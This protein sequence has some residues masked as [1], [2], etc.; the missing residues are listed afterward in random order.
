MESNFWMGMAYGC[1]EVW[2]KI[3]Q[4]DKRV[5][6]DLSGNLA[7]P[8]RPSINGFYFAFIKLALFHHRIHMQHLLGARH[9]NGSKPAARRLTLP[10]MLISGTIPRRRKRNDSD[11]IS[12]P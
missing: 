7:K 10:F 4:R 9:G 12:L 5:F 11:G 8:P 2:I 6:D 3:H 1:S